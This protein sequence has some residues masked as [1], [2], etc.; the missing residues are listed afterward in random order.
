MTYCVGLKLDRGIVFASDTRTNAGVDNIAVYSKM[1]VWE[2]KGDRVLVLMSAGNLAF[3][4]AVVSLLQERV[5]APGE[6]SS[7]SLVNVSTMFQAARA[8]GEAIREYRRSNQDMLTES[9]MLADGS[10]ILGG[11]IKDDRPRL[12]QIYKEG[13]FIEASGDTPYF[14]IGEHKYGKPILGR[15]GG[16]E[17]A[18]EPHVAFCR[19]KPVGRIEADPTEIVHI[20][21]GPGVVGDTHLLAGHS[22]IAGHITRRHLN[23][24]RRRNENMRVVLADALPG[25][26]RFGRTRPGVGGVGQIGDARS[27]GLHQIV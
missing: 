25:R 10:F 17:A 6:P 19:A 13:N 21:F 8:V 22:Q 9:P 11:Q 4:Q 14:Q 2:F 12:F 18:G 7:A 20:G 27:D 16:V 24:S 23:R 3:T 26:Q 1:H 15:R 5:N